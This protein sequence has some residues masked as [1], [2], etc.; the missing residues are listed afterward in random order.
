MADVNL[1]T[2]IELSLL[3]LAILW[4]LSGIALSVRVW[5]ARA[6]FLFFFWSVP[7]FA[8]GWIFLGIPVIAMGTQIL[9][10]SYVV[11]G[12]SGAI[13]GLFIMLLPTGWLVAL[14]AIQFKL[15]WSI[16]KSWPGFG[17][18]IGAGGML[19]YRWLLSRAVPSE[20]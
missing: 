19:F 1:T 15:D 11:V 2:R 16:L 4:F 14:G 5:D 10:L 9:K 12:L 18:A 8:I 7:F 20:S 3:A 17:A 6:C 13:V